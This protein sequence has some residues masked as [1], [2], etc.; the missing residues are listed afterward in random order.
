MVT[1]PSTGQSSDPSLMAS[2]T[3][4]AS[5]ECD[6]ASGGSKD[7]ADCKEESKGIK[8]ETDNITD[9]QA[10]SDDAP[11]TAATSL[12]GEQAI[13]A[14]MLEATKGAF[15]LP[16][17]SEILWTPR[18]APANDSISS[19]NPALPSSDVFEEILANLRVTFLPKTQHQATWASSEESFVE[20]TFALYCPIQGGSHY[21][22]ET[23]RELS[24]Q[25][26]AEVVVLDAM[27]LISYEYARFSEGAR[28]SHEPPTLIA[29][30]QTLPQH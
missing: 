4:S 30:I 27:I 23:V 6:T 12:D 22:D 26:G 8:T 7:A 25:T 21:I 24:H 20:P 13:E 28:L 9:S 3:I 17:T 10:T 5:H 18:A 16:P 11:N 2:A 29:I 19:P 1:T 14:S 15:H